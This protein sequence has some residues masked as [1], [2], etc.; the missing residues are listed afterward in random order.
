MFIL[1][2]GFFEGVLKL[3]G[4]KMV[5]SW[6]AIIIGLDLNVFVGGV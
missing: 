4:R 3:F 2:V 5:L 1:N 6:L